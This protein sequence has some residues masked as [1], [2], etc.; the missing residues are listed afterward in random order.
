MHGRFQA[1][2]CFLKIFVR[3]FLKAKEFFKRTT[4][5]LWNECSPPLPPPRLVQRSDN[6]F[7]H[8][9]HISFRMLHL[10]L[11]I[12]LSSCRNLRCQWHHV[13]VIKSP[14][15]QIT[16]FSCSSVFVDKLL[17]IFSNFAMQCSMLCSKR[18]QYSA[19]SKCRYIIVSRLCEMGLNLIFSGYFAIIKCG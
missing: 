7:V 11:I 16:Q 1:K 14:K 3:V 13:S 15:I 12:R 6:C 2:K 5:F 18:Y 4:R 19:A 8:H 9:L 17:C 10:L